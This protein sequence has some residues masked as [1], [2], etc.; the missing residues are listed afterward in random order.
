VIVPSNL[1]ALSRHL[2]LTN[3]KWLTG[4][5]DTAERQRFATADTSEY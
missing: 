2:F 3:N 4:R 1:R 5:K